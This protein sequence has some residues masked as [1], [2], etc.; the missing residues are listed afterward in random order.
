MRRCAIAAFTSRSPSPF[1]VI[2][3]STLTRFE[4]FIETKVTQFDDFLHGE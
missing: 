1:V 4:H 3:L 2:W